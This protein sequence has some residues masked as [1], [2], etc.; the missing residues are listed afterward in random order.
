MAIYE[1]NDF[2]IRNLESADAPNIYEAV[3]SNRSLLEADFPGVAAGYL[4]LSGAQARVEGVVRQAKSN[5]LTVVVATNPENTKFYGMATCQR[6]GRK[7]IRMLGISWQATEPGYV[8]DASLVAGWTVPEHPDAL[9]VQ[10]LKTL[11]E[12]VSQPDLD[13][14]SG[15]GTNYVTAALIRPDHAASQRVAREAGMHFTG[16]T[17]PSIRTKLANVGVTGKQ[18][19]WIVERPHESVAE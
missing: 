18:G 12:D 7:A 10:A 19:L 4:S 5:D 17:L 8:L 15:Y 16:K 13:V 9:P 14:A 3:A 11:I 2:T 6:I 1:N